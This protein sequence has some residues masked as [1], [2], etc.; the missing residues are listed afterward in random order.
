M[1]IGF[2]SLNPLATLPARAT[3]GS[4]GYDLELLEDTS[5]QVG[6]VNIAPCGLRLADGLPTFA[7]ASFGN[8][9]LAMLILPRSSLFLKYGLIIPNS[10]GLVDVDY[11]GPIGVVLWRPGNPSGRP[12][13]IDLSLPARTR[14]AQALFVPVALPTVSFGEAVDRP[15]RAGFGSTG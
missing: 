5:W 3:S 9:A 15:A 13:V 14:V 1:N 8:A 10:P 12:H 6:D 11:T 2:T 7:D 4:L